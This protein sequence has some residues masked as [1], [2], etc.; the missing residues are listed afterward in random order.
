MN[1]LTQIIIYSSLAGITVF[2]GGILAFYFEP[3]LKKEPYKN[4]LNF[5][6]AFGGGIIISAVAL[7][8][9]PEGTKSL[10]IFKIITSFA[11][12]SISFYLFDKYIE[13]KGEKLAQLLTMLMD[14]IPESIALGATFA[15]N[16]NTGLILAIF[17][18]LQ[19]LPESFNAYLELKKSNYKTKTSLTMLFLLSFSGLIAALLGYYLLSSKQNLIACLMIYASGGI[20]YLIFQDIAPQSK[21]KN[22]WTPALGAC[23]GFLIG[24]TGHQIISS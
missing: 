10:S 3:H 12:G 24:M 8:L 19:N 7:V 2:I 14:F 22:N 20:L 18:G 13:K 1:Q 5:L 9:I 11:L 6:I 23:L 4:F 21:V 17:I 15:I 16:P